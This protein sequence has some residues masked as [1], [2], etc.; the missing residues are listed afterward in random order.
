MLF[1]ANI[2]RKLKT[3]LESR[4][5]GSWTLIRRGDQEDEGKRKELVRWQLNAESS[6]GGILS[7]YKKTGSFSDATSGQS[8]PR[9]RFDPSSHE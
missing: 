6:R 7:S 3:S 9:H 2:V 8:L 1:L 5:K 4:E